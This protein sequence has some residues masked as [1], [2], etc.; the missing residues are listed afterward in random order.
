MMKL[1]HSLDTTVDGP[2]L[3]KLASHVFSEAFITVSTQPLY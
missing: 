1:H 3:M 2:E